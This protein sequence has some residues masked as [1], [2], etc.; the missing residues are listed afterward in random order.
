MTEWISWGI[1]FLLACSAIVF[2]L[3]PLRSNKK[4][5]ALLGLLMLLGI[6]L[7]YCAW[8]GFAQWQHHEHKRQQQQE[9]QAMLGSIGST[10]VLIERVKARLD[11][12]PASA[13]G[14]YLIGKLYLSQGD[15][16]HA[17]EAFALALNL[18]PND[19]QTLLHYAQTVWNGHH[20]A[21]DKHTRTLLQNLLQ[22]NPNQPDALAML[23]MDA[24]TRHHPKIAIRY[25]ERL[26]TLVPP[27]SNEAK[28]IR[29]ALSNARQQ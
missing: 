9:V 29:Q 3:Y 4:V 19:E 17:Q 7:L 10:D 18:N 26:L 2:S 20:Q 12:T 11:K 15:N 14:W 23:A 16:A 24:F 27:D 28:S 1:F 21:F 25:W 8:G 5:C 6:F 22:K 13:H